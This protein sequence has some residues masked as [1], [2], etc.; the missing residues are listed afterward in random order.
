MNSVKTAS[1]HGVQRNEVYLKYL[2]KPDYLQYQ[3]VQGTVT[4]I[5]NE[6]SALT[7]KVYQSLKAKGRQVV[8]L[9]LP[10]QHKP[11][12]EYQYSLDAYND[13]AVKT[14]I[15]NIEQ[16]YGTVSDFIHLHP[17][18]E[19]K[20]GQFAQHFETERSIVKTVFLLA[21]YLQKSLNIEKCN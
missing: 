11:V 20:N 10:N 13:L 9:N 14:A 12:A 8:V 4:L 1:F 5:T 2:P 17:H 19:F 6:G 15:A 18:F 3:A 16:Q 21:K 7:E